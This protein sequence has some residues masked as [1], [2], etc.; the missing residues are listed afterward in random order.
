[1]VC[2]FLHHFVYFPLHYK[3][4]RGYDCNGWVGICVVEDNEGNVCGL[5]VQTH[6]DF[7]SRRTA[8]KTPSE[9]S[10]NP[11]EKAAFT[12]AASKAGVRPSTRAPAP[13]K[14]A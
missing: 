6:D 1:M 9:A 8:S 7:I 2:K 13:L 12:L 11:T 3:L 14:G 4:R 10:P 5:S